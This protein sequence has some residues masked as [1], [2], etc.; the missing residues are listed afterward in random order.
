MTPLLYQ[1]E[2]RKP[3]LDFLLFM[4]HYPVFLQCP[5]LL[6][7]ICHQALHDKQDYLFY[8]YLIDSYKNFVR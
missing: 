8:C 4:S 6:T 7:I 1:I 2:G 5:V 3:E